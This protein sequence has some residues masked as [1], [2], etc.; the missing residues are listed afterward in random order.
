M[1]WVRN[2]L[3]IPVIGAALALWWLADRLAWLSKATGDGAAWLMGP[4]R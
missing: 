4:D 2:A 3:A 1:T